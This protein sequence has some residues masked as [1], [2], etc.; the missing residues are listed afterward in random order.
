MASLAAEHRLWHAQASIVEVCGLSSCGTQVYL[1]QGTWNLP[2][3]GT[4]PV[5]P[6]LIGK[7]LTTGPPGKSFAKF[8]NSNR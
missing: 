3:S 5:S 4:E 2:R 7:F 6:A 1:T 8:F